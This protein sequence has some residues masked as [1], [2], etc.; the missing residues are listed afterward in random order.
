MFVPALVFTIITVTDLLISFMLIMPVVTVS[1]LIAFADENLAVRPM[2][3]IGGIFYAVLVI[4]NI[5]SGIIQNY[6]MAV[7]KIKMRISRGKVIRKYP[8]VIGQVYKLVSGDKIIAANIRD[9]II[10]DMI[11]SNRSPGWLV[12]N[13]D[14][15]GNLGGSL[16]KGSRANENSKSEDE[17]FHKYFLFRPENKT[18]RL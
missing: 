10:I 11:I 18:G 9:I 15:D 8:T 13:I 12:M 16:P 4:M 3:S 1:V 17:L 14:V 6:F 5:G 7:K 2:S